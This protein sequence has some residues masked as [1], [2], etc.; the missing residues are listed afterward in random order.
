[1]NPTVATRSSPLSRRRPCV[2]LAL[3]LL[4]VGQ[5][6]L[7]ATI[8]VTRNDDPAPN[9]C[10]PG[11]CSLREAVAAANANVDP[12]LIQVPAANY[13]LPRGKLTLTGNVQ[14][15]GDTDATT[16]VEG[17]GTFPVFD[18]VGAADVKLARVTIQAHGAHAIDGEPDAN[19][20]L[21][22]VTVPEND[23]QIVVGG[24]AN[25]NGSLS[26]R[27]SEIH[28]AI[29]CGNIRDCR[30]QE[31][32]QIFRLKA[33]T[34]SATDM[35]VSITNSIID[36]DLAVGDSGA[37][38]ATNGDV[39]VAYSTIQN[40]SLGLQVRLGILRSWCLIVSST[41]ATQRRS[42]SATRRR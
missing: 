1:M 37:V 33:G 29:D 3:L 25:S 20:I 13:G 39:N 40:T 8:V 16:K 2:R 21:E 18:I 32:S 28:S 38:I 41:P 14:I 24:A 22:F 4:V 10:L 30:V 17:D 12:D 34:S 6:A 36:G 26:V 11:D 5:C 42:M 9:G 19:T 27:S 7:G 15:F 31:G 35:F 23:S